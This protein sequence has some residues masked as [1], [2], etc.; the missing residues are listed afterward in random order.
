MIE[1]ALAACDAYTSRTKGPPGRAE[2]RAL[3]D[4]ARSLEAQLAFARKCERFH[5]AASALSSR[6]ANDLLLEVIK[7]RVR[8]VVPP[9]LISVVLC[10]MAALSGWLLHC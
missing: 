3:T 6:R 9:P 7:P 2:I 4:H 10:A 5:L 1:H 8:I